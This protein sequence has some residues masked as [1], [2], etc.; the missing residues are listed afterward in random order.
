MGGERGANPNPKLASSL[1]GGT[2]PP[3]L[4]P[5]T[6]TPSVFLLFLMFSDFDFFFFD[7]SLFDVLRFFRNVFVFLFIFS[8]IFD[9]FVTFPF[10]LFLRQ[11]K[12]LL[13]HF[14]AAPPLC[15]TAPLQDL[16][17]TALRWSAP[18]LGCPTFRSCFSSSRR[19][20]RSFF[21]LRRVFSWNCGRCSWPRL[22]HV[23]FRNDAVSCYGTVPD[24][25]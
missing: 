17:W 13:F 8:F 12:I 14:F 23:L 25:S 11:G 19:T 22:T 7:F 16:R 2:S 9:F 3:L 15:R 10:S 6:R 5:Q 24:E 20:F 1:G 18:P 21:P 4:P